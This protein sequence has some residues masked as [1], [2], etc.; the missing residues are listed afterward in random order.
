MA[1]HKVPGPG[2]APLSVKRDTDGMWATISVAGELDIAIAPILAD[3]L[4]LEELPGG[5]L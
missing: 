3:A 1:G 5:R 4:R 2:S